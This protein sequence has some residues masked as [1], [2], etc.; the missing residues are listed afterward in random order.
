MHE[1]T[2]LK[3]Q[4]TA[5][6]LVELLLADD[7]TFNKL[8]QQKK[9][10]K[11]VERVSAEEIKTSI[12]MHGTLSIEKSITLLKNVEI[13]GDIRIEGVKKTLPSLFCYESKL[14]SIAVIDS[15]FIYSKDGAN[16][17]FFK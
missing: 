14:N 17:Y 4:L 11:F 15:G 8:I 6:V 16:F 7:D 9:I 2:L 13:I 10:Q 1:E 3:H 5:D 12:D